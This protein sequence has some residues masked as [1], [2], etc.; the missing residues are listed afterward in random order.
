VA[1]HGVDAT[2]YDSI[3]FRPFNFRAA[4]PVNSGGDFANVTIIPAP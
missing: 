3:Y 4:D 1:F 2:T